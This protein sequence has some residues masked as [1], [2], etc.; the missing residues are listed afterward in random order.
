MAC[1]AA[2]L[3]ARGGRVRGAL[4]AG[5]LL[6]LTACGLGAR[7]QLAHWRD[8]ASL[9]RR[10]VAVNERNAPAHQG[11]GMALLEQDE[12]EAARRHLARALEL[13][14]DF[15][16]AHVNLGVVLLRSG[17]LEGARRHLE[18]G[19]GLPPE[20]VWRVRVWLAQ[21]ERR[22]G[23]P[24]PALEHARR[25]LAEQPSRSGLRVEEGLALL[26]LGRAAEAGREL[27]RAEREGVDLPELHVAL[28]RV[29][30]ARGDGAEAIRRYRRALVL[31]PEWPVAANNLAW[32]LATE[33]SPTLRDPEAAVRLAERAAALTGRDDPNV[34]DTLSVALDAA[35]RRG[36]AV[37]TARRAARLARQRGATALADG[38]EARLE[39][40][41]SEDASAPAATDRTQREQ[42]R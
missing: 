21:L 6:A 27:A 14:P 16:D 19:L 3:G 9:F 35:G 13:D 18:R 8:S 36:E 5:A 26:D 28:A 20:R 42:G 17:E 12:P 22:A 30:A 31:R 25:A 32:L 23:R 41:A 29:A 10:A 1:S 11:L 24:G 33:R 40:W 39:R 4:V 37:A 38:V 34:L 15:V 7:L 2:E